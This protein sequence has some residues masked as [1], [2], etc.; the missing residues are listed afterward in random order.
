LEQVTY[1]RRQ[2]C[3]WVRV[4]TSPAVWAALPHVVL[5]AACRLAPLAL[6]GA[7]GAAQLPA[8]PTPPSVPAS[9]AAPAQ[10][11]RE[12]HGGAP[13]PGWGALASTPFSVAAAGRPYRGPVGPG[14]TGYVSPTAPAQDPAASAATD[15]SVLGQDPPVTDVPEPS[16]LALFLTAALLLV[17]VAMGATP[18]RRRAPVTGRAR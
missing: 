18:W 2:G 14:D 10:P 4:T 5:G 12:D 13:F 11:T 6:A 8:L 9:P 16:S 7:I 1:F 3:A 15:A 17:P